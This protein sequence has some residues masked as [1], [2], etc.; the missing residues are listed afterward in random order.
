MRD[1]ESWNTEILTKHNN[2]WGRDLLQSEICG[3]DWPRYQVKNFFNSLWVKKCSMIIHAFVIC[4][5]EWAVKKK[6]LKKKHLKGEY[7]I[8]KPQTLEL[9]ERLRL[10]VGPVSNAVWRHD[11]KS[12]VYQD[13]HVQRCKWGGLIHFQ[14]NRK[15]SSF[16]FY[17]K[18]RPT[19]GDLI[20]WWIRFSVLIL[21]VQLVA[22][23]SVFVVGNKHCFSRSTRMFLCFISC[24]RNQV[25][26]HVVFLTG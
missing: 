18:H 8:G 13:S 7:S 15:C 17:I 20:S 6:G 21:F 24:K 9:H 16:F 11:H 5:C 10:K 25:V 2:L 4:S 3:T 1:D 22:H 14:T 19:E 26:P 12:F 23:L